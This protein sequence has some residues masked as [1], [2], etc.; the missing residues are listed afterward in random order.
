MEMSP[1]ALLP[2]LAETSPAR[3]QVFTWGKAARGRLGRTDGEACV[4]GPVQLQETFPYAVTSVSSRHGIRT[5]RCVPYSPGI[6]TCEISAWCP[7]EKATAPRRPV[8]A[9]AENFT[10][11]IKN[12]I[13]FPKFDFSK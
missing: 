12:T 13:R 2:C 4:P 11:F 5:G 7:V 1:Q 3:G 6:R 10:V 9:G 8:L